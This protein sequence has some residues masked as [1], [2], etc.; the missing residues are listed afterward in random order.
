MNRDPRRNDV[1]TA[2]DVFFAPCVASG[3]C[4]RKDELAV[5][6][7]EFPKSAHFL[8]KPRLLPVD[9]GVA[10]QKL[11]TAS[12]NVVRR[13]APQ[14]DRVE[15]EFLQQRN[16]TNIGARRIALD[17]MTSAQGGGAA[18]PTPKTIGDLTRLEMGDRVQI[19]LSFRHEAHDTP[20][21]SGLTPTASPRTLTTRSASAR[22]E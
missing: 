8:A 17:T 13:K 12:N 14:K 4:Q 20:H 6:Q 15:I 11:D 2:L 21:P 5:M 16:A 10:V 19:Q 3:L 18:Q 22:R 7:V 1:L 9:T